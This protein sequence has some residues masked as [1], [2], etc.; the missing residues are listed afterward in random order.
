MSRIWASDAA[1]S[2]PTRREGGARDQRGLPA[3]RWSRLSWPSA[4]AAEGREDEPPTP[5]PEGASTAVDALPWQPG[6]FGPHARSLFG[7][8]HPPSLGGDPSPLAVLLCSPFGCEDQS[9]HRSL[10]VL[11]MRLA[12]AGLPVLRFDMD[13]CGDSAGHDGDPGRVAAWLAS[14]GSAVDALRRQSGCTQVA[15]VGVRLGALLA[16]QVARTR[17]VLNADVALL[18]AIAPVVSGRRYLRE[19]LALGSMRGAS[20]EA[21]RAGDLLESG[22]YYFTPST[23]D[24][25]GQLDLAHTELRALPA[26]HVFDR[27]EMPTVGPWLKRLEADRVPVTVESFDGYATWMDEPHRAV[28]PEA[29]WQSVVRTLVAKAGQLRLHPGATG[30]GAS[31]LRFGRAVAACDAMLEQP[32]QIPLGAGDNEGEPAYNL[33]GML[34]RPASGLPVRRAVLMLNAGSIRRVG[35]SR[36][37]LSLARSW[38]PQGVMVLRLDLSG[39]GDSAPAPGQPDNVVYGH[40]ALAEVRAAVAWLLDNSGLPQCT[41]LGL[42]AGGSHGLKV[43]QGLMRGRQPAIEQVIALNPLVFDPVPGQSLDNPWAAHRLQGMRESFQQPLWDLA[44]WQRLW[45]NNRSVPELV[46]KAR[47]LAVWQVWRQLRRLGEALHLPMRSALARTLDRLADQGTRLQFVFASD[48]PGL[49]LLREQGGR[50]FVRRQR[51]GWVQVH[52]VHGADHVFI[53][54]DARERVTALLD[55]AVCAGDIPG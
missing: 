54:A 40:R 3:S 39:L 18:M 45:H 33:L 4:R 19:C 22:G 24:A 35:P 51:E 14:M 52:Q 11:A 6:F 34:S 20:G 21:A 31:A 47:R 13:G 7:C 37:Y 1:W 41:V 36:L 43:A 42:C 27:A 25:L 44:R 55:A 2:T 28:V 26:V 48:E 49:G 23:R 46:G 16:A 15:L 5:L 53:S 10:K 17:S 8:Y 50:T 29:L 30:H 32:V 9:A 38:A 12:Q